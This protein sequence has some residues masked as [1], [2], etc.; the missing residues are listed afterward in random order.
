MNHPEAAGF[1][2]DAL[3][4]QG[5][6]RLLHMHGYQP[7]DRA[8]VRA[9]G[10]VIQREE[11]EDIFLADFLSRDSAP[12]DTVAATAEANFC[13]ELLNVCVWNGDP[14]W[15][16]RLARLWCA[17][18]DTGVDARFVWVCTGA[19]LSA[20]RERL[21]G[22]RAEIFQLELDL[23]T[24]LVRVVWALAAHLSEVSVARAR[25]QGG[26]ATGGLTGIGLPDRAWFDT[27]VEAMVAAATPEQ[28]VGLVLVRLQSTP[29]T[30]ALM[31]AERA[32]IRRA[33]SMRWREALRVDDVLCALGEQEWALLQPGVQTAGQ[34]LLA[35]NKLRELAHGVLSSVDLGEGIDVTIGGACAP[36]DGTDATTL[37]R[38]AR[39]A[40]NLSGRG[41]QGVTLFGEAVAKAM[42]VE[43]EAE[44][45][46]LR[47][48]HLQRFELY[49]QPQINSVDG[50]CVSAEAL[51]RWQRDDGKW[52]PPPAIF[53]LAARLGQHTRLTRM[54][55]ARIARMADEL[56]RS[57]VPVRVM[58]NLTAEDL[59]DPELPDLVQQSMANWHVAPGRIGFEL[60]EGAVLSDDPVVETVLDRLRALK[61]FIALDDFGTG[62]S[63]LAHLRRLPVDELKVDRQFVAG[64]HA[65]A[66]DRAIVEAVLALARAFD[67]ETVAE[68]VETSVQSK[69][70]KEMG[71]LRL[72]GNLISPAVPASRF[73]T[74]WL[75]RSR[76]SA[77]PPA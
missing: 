8:A 65:N 28:R 7:E 24:G 25:V 37:E 60:T 17:C 35:A 1:Q 55:V 63:S 27:M 49:L 21:V 20:C 3:D 75:A 4:A 70:L 41:R 34:V 30:D 48:M 46:F 38:A 71:C 51:L 45:E 18:C 15:F 62:Y 69:L 9:F 67:L 31:P 42:K 44:R 12:V 50:Q 19:L 16:N 59:H 47:A 58:L 54:L 23:L 5:L 72:Q 56:S 73:V 66:Q 29:V 14:D 77:S 6:A 26:R 32:S 61:A 10:R 68:G 53:D 36:D 64:M 40:L 39:A 57:G 33:L 13:D 2:P 52:M 74:W 76:S 22:G 11:L 43:H